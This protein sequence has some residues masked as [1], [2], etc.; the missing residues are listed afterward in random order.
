[1]LDDLPVP[2]GAFGYRRTPGEAGMLTFLLPAPVNMDETVRFY[3]AALLA[4]GCATENET[5]TETV[6]A[7]VCRVPTD[8]VRRLMLTV[9]PFQTQVVVSAFW[10]RVKEAPSSG[11]R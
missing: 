4:R 6:A 11:A 3:R 10:D 8:R 7:I 9:V 2:Q 1:L 5:R